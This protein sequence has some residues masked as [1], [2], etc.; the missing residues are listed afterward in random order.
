M[1]TLSSRVFDNFTPSTDTY[2]DLRFVLTYL[3][4]N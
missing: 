1:L 4:L 2:I 3:N